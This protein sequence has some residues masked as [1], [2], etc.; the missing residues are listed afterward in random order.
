MY[1]DLDPVLGWRWRAYPKGTYEARSQGLR[2]DR[3]SKTPA[4]RVE[5]ETQ[6]PANVPEPL[7]SIV[8]SPMYDMSVPS[9]TNLMASIPI[10]PPGLP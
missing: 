1:R 8:Q 6:S 7:P 9:T 4:G 10:L 3:E 2:E 5:L